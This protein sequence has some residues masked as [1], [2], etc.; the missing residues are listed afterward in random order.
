MNKY[1]SFYSSGEGSISLVDAKSE[2]FF[3]FVDRSSHLAGVF[4]V[5]GGSSTTITILSSLRGVHFS[6]D[7]DVDKSFSDLI[8]VFVWEGMGEVFCRLV[9]VVSDS[10][11]R[12]L[13]SEAEDVDEDADE[14]EEVGVEDVYCV[15][16]VD[17]KSKL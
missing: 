9:V 15:V 8:F 1:H 14:G 12:L 16:F 13:F 17:I 6:V 2:S 11:R 5:A 3:I 4:F 7:S 10:Y